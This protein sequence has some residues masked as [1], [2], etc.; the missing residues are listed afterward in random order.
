MPFGDGAEVP[1]HLRD[2][3]VGLAPF[4]PS[5]F[6]ALQLGWFWSP[7][8]IFEYLAAGLMV[9]TADI[10]ELRRVLTDATARFYAPGDPDDL[11]ETLT[12]LAS[13]DVALARARRDGRLLAEQRYTWGH[14]AAAVERVLEDVVARTT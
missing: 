8:K 11:A 14:Q 12:R 7:I 5:E 6:G 3:D 2:A 13:D 10:P 1:G 4:S 9:V